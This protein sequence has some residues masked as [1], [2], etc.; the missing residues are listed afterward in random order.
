MMAFHF[1]L[2]Q[3]EVVSENKGPFING[4]TQYE[5]GG[6]FVFKDLLWS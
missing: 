2:N 4:L 3:Y 5:G 6:K 1:A